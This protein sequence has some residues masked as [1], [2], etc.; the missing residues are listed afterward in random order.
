MKTKHILLAVGTAFAGLMVYAYKRVTETKAIM[1]QMDIWPSDI[2]NIAA[3]LTWFRFNISF[4]IENPTDADF[5]VSG[6]GL[7]TV[8]RIMVYR[9][10]RYLGMSEVNISDIEIP[11]KT[12]R[13]IK[14][15]PFKIETANVLRNILTIESFSLEEL[16]IVAVLEVLGSEYTLES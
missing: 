5:S 3:G 1:Q 8:K 14:H 7:I 6:L 2:S 9:K 10:G 11:A 13:E 15:I 16:R 12:T 4:K